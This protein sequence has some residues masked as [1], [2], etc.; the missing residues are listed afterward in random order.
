MK[1]FEKRLVFDDKSPCCPYPWYTLVECLHAN[2]LKYF[3]LSQCSPASPWLLT[4]Y[5]SPHPSRPYPM[6]HTPPSSPTPSLLL[7]TPH[8]LH[9]CYC[10]NSYSTVIFFFSIQ[11][12]RDHF[13]VVW[14]CN[15]SFRVEVW[16]I[17]L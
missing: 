15:A 17:S 9:C 16:D 2:I 11:V 14:S 5:C 4:P 6:V 1:I 7:R 12:S 3:F 13:T 8:H 10:V